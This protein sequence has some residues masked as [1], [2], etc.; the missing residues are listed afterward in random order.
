MIFMKEKKENSVSL[1]YLRM[2][3]VDNLRIAM[4]QLKA[5]AEETLKKIESEGVSG[6]YSCNSDVRRFSEKA[7]WAS[8]ALSELKRFEDRMENEI[9]R[10]VE[11]K[12]E[13]LLNTVRSDSTEDKE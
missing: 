4:N 2:H 10:A 3:H 9:D 5:C 1:D 8:L 6:Y 11:A 7:W 12:L 13:K